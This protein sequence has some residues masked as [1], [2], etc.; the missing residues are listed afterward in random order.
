[1]G[2]LVLALP[3]G[4]LKGP[5]ERWLVAVQYAAL[6]ITQTVRY[7]VEYPPQ[8]QVWGDPH[9][10]YSVWAAVGSVAMMVLTLL[11]IS[12]V[13]RHWAMA[14]R[15][16]R[17]EYALVWMTITVMAAV[18]VANTVG[19]LLDAPLSVQ[20]LMQLGYALG[21]ILTPITLAAGLLRVRM[22]RVRVADLIVA[23]E[24]S[25][26]PEHLQRAIAHALGDPAL[27]VYFPLSGHQGYVRPDGGRV[28]LPQAADRALTTVIRHGETLAVL[29]HDP[30]LKR[31]RP[32]IESVLATARLAL[33]NAR[34]LAMQRAQ[35]E[36]L[37]ASRT[38]IVLAADT[39]RRRIQ[40]DLHDGVQ[41]KLLA[42]SMLVE[43]ARHG[44]PERGP[45]D[46]VPP[47]VSPAP[48][49]RL[50]SAAQQLRE[51]IHDLRLLTEAIHPPV[52]TEQGLAAAVEVIAERAP[53]PIQA[54]VPARRWPEHL[55]RAAYFVISEALG[56]I[57][58][59]ANASRAWVRVGDDP[60][61]LVLQ[62]GDDGLGGADISSG[63]GLRG[64]RDRIGAL[65]G[66]LRVDSPPG[67]GTR[68]VAELPCES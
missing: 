49:N 21:L 57:Y 10:A 61:Q 25:A 38:R 45:A 64:L 24:Q 4:R 12:L 43:Q 41:H 62:V 42:I 18:I 60:H 47:G 29:V 44:L 36:E 16:V 13:I 19:A 39:E 6:L 14:G 17:R 28:E 58:K 50:A 55:E 30:A 2:H 3:S 40:R 54:D 67:R 7:V 8:P 32:L 5:F 34:L 11:T 68:V 37:R 27:E 1:M 52:L 65:G 26:E 53:L 9:A 23:L 48:V 51:T 15:P 56:N 22:A 31:Q 46:P 66:V 33:D 63:T 59:H 35:L 20:R